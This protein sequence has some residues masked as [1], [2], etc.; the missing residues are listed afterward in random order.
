MF[1]YLNEHTL[2]Y[3][4]GCG[5]AASNFGAGDE[6]IPRYTSAGTHTWVINSH[7]VNEVNWQWARQT[8]TTRMS[9]DY[10]PANCNAVRTVLAG[11]R[12][13]ARATRSQAASSGATPSVC[14]PACRT[15][16]R[17]RRSRTSTKRCQSAWVITTGRSAARY[18]NYKTHEDA[19]PN[20][21][22]TWTFS[23]DQYFNPSDPNFD[24]N[25]LTGARQFQMTWPVVFAISRIISIPV[26][27]RTN[28]R[29]DR[30]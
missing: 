28:G 16:G 5:G 19:A 7:M 9:Q 3:C 4:N 1:R 15:Q 12:R 2:F 11:R 24:F 6:F 13:A 14:H 8:D 29:C 23:A 20:P 17:R 22:G 27:P 25:K 10:T 30:A 21:L 26:M 18:S